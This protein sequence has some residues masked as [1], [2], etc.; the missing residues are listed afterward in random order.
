MAAAEL[1]ERAQ[2]LMLIGKPAL[3]LCDYRDAV[4]VGADPERIAP[5][6]AA[7]DVDGARRHACMMLVENPAHRPSPPDP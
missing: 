1:V 6:A 2:E 3:V 5:P 4:A 7:T